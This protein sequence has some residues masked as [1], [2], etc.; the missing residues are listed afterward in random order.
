M[1][2]QNQRLRA[3]AQDKSLTENKQLA[4]LPEVI[5]GANS[6]PGMLQDPNFQRIW[7][8]NPQNMRDFILQQIGNDLYQLETIA[9]REGVRDNP[10]NLALVRDVA[11]ILGFQMWCWFDPSIVAAN[12]FRMTP[13]E[14]L[15]FGSFRGRS[16]R[17]AGLQ[18]AE[19]TVDHML[20]LQQADKLGI[21]LNETD[22]MREMMGEAGGFALFDVN[23]RFA[24]QRRVKD[25][26]R[27]GRGDRSEL[28]GTP[29]DLL[30]ALTDEFR[31]V[32]AQGI[33]TGLEPGVRAFRGLMG[34]SSTPAN[35]SPDEFLRYVREQRTTSRVQ[36]L[37]VPLADFVGKVTR[38]PTEEELRSRFDRY[39]SREPDPTSVEPGFKE[40]RRVSQETVSASITDPFYRDAAAKVTQTLSKLS[41]VKG[42]RLGSFLTGIN[43]TAL[44]R[45]FVTFD[46]IENDYRRIV[47]RESGEEHYW[48]Y[49]NSD[50]I[51][52]L[53]R[54][55]ATLHFANI[56]E[57]NVQATA[58]ARTLT[59]TPGGTALEA[60]SG[61]YA[62]VSLAKTKSS[63]KFSMSKLLAMADPGQTWAAAAITLAALPSPV[64]REQVLPELLEGYQENIA[65]EML[66]ANL[67]KLSE[68]LVKFRGRANAGK[69][70]VAKAVKEYHLKHGVMSKALTRDQF[71]Q[72]LKSKSDPSVLALRTL[73][74]NRVD[75]Q[76]TRL[77]MEFFTM[78]IFGDPR[79][80]NT[81]TG[82]Y[83]ALRA[84]Q[85]RGKTEILYWRNEDSPA[86]ERTFA[87][88]RE[89]VIQ[90]WKEEEARILAR[91]E[92]ERIEDEINKNK[93]WSA[94]DAER[95]LKEQQKNL[96]SSSMF[97]LDGVA[98]LV[99]AREVMMRPRT[100][101][102]FYEMPLE[103]LDVLEYPPFDLTTQ[104]TRLTRPG[105]ATVISDRPKRNYFVTVL[106]DRNEPSVAEFK[107]LYSQTPE[108]DT[109][110]S[111][112]QMRL[113]ENYRK[114]VIDQLR[115]ESGA[116]DAE[117][118]YKWPEAFKAQEARSQTESE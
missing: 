21:R 49:N 41:D 3:L 35:G 22:V 44:E 33:L 48:F 55:D 51:D 81:I 108:R 77:E 65:R 105:Q 101:Y 37:S 53:R 8:Q 74:D 59:G 80:P 16:R 57:P 96:K 83:D 38:K 26:L 24:D 39:R 107:Q 115:A 106:M 99:K 79:N 68:D 117:G 9:V 34:A 58:I 90:A 46:P 12:L 73:L 64:T 61:L 72:A 111:R 84:E 70:V 4:G 92:A 82:E 50:G 87:E 116:G 32:M 104:I 28:Q 40:P 112:F 54:R 93:N 2:G 15:F 52:I 7:Q 36:F 19:E 20:W 88:A 1:D 62:N 109:L 45:L 98:Q 94:A 11:R 6:R 76:N 75:R 27:S 100:E 30:Q 14:D 67:N 89:L 102:Q 95:F 71:L 31:A 97:E 86:R 42:A 85:D 113:R 13:P 23:A 5:R 17:E 56:L 29:K 114:A 110:F 118:K 60:I 10:E 78:R 43:G 63:L 47:S 18:R 103:K 25:F 66:L 91:K 69:E